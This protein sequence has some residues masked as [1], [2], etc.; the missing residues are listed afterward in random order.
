MLLRAE[1]A[2][3]LV[4]TDEALNQL[5]SVTCGNSARG[6]VLIYDFTVR[7]ECW[8]RARPVLRAFQGLVTL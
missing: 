7:P 8:L 4:R 2:P 1:A 6:E 5:K 3:K